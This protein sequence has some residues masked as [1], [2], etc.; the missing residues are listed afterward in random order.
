MG[1]TV[2][3][4]TLKDGRVYPQTVI[5]SGFLTRVRGYSHIPFGE[6]EIAAIEATHQKWDWKIEP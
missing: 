5:D 1:Y 6:A 3:S 4:V 2:A